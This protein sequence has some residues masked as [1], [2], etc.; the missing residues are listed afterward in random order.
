MIDHLTK[1]GQVAV[2][3]VRNLIDQLVLEAGH[4]DEKRVARA[5]RE[6]CDAWIGALATEWHE[7]AGV[8]FTQRRQGNGLYWYAYRKGRSQNVEYLGAVARV[9]TE[10][11]DAVKVWEKKNAG[12]KRK[13]KSVSR[14][15]V[16]P[17][18]PHSGV[19]LEPTGEPEHQKA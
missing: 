18:A 12:K 19:G 13:S 5:I 1:P 3:G 9:G 6:H 8:R 15:T 17:R 2:K 10:D 11:E 7:V 16:K 14:K 4:I